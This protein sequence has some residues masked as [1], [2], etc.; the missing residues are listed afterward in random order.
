MTGEATKVELYGANNDG[1]PRSY[2]CA[3]NAAIAKGT[4]LSLADGR[5]AAKAAAAGCMVAG[6][7]AMG[8]AADDFSTTIS[9]WTDGVLDMVAS[10]S[11][12]FGYP[13]MSAAVTAWP[14][15][16][17]HASLTASGAVI[18]GYAL[19]SVTTGNRV[20]IRLRL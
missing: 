15:T 11:I 12:I 9:A 19:D 1:T 16:V 2:I 10:G 4:I 6:V 5:V 8:K 18:I 20:N 3:S 17:A 14:N 13:V 7:A